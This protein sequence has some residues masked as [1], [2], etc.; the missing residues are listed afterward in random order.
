M[1]ERLAVYLIL[2]LPYLH[3]IL[4]IIVVTVLYWTLRMAIGATK[5]LM[6]VNS[7][8]IADSQQIFLL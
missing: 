7:N 3:L 5:K 2:T 8:V 4:M 1:V 6:L